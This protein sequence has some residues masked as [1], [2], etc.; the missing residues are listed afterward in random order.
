PETR[1][2]AGRYGAEA[3]RRQRIAYAVARP[4]PMSASALLDRLDGVR[5]LGADRWLARCPAHDDRRASLSVRELDDGRTLVH[6]FA[7]C[8]VEAVL[9]A[10]GLDFDSL[11]PER[12]TDHYRERISRPFPASDILR[13][14]ADEALVVVVTACS[15]LSGDGMSI[16][17]RE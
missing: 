15:I 16:E 5:Q 7:G 8:S 1:E 13:A 17:A 4:I 9:S 10:V 12:A 11:F 2:A 6:D 14:V 3:R